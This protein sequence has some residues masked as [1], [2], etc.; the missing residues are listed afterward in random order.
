MLLNMRGSTAQVFFDWEIVLS[1]YIGADSGDCAAQMV[2]SEPLRCTGF[3]SS[4]QPGASSCW[5][6]Q[7]LPL[8][9]RVSL[10]LACYKCLLTVRLCLHC[11]GM[12]KFLS[13]RQIGCFMP[14]SSLSNH[15]IGHA[16]FCQLATVP[17][18]CSLG[19]G[20][21]ACCLTTSVQVIVESN[22]DSFHYH[23]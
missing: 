15:G 21:A 4:P 7:C 9:V 11:C 3:F 10:S 14:K 5:T 2:S 13:S 17:H 19:A 1:L 18:L 6:R 12:F 8:I 20:I 23:T 22:Y 16:C